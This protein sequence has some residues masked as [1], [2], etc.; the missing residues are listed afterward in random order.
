MV[1]ILATRTAIL[2]LSLLQAGL[3]TS[4]LAAPTAT[5]A[6]VHSMIKSNA[7]KP[8]A[9]G[10][11]GASGSSA[12]DHSNPRA[13]AVANVQ[14][15]HEEVQGHNSII[16]SICEKDKFD[17]TYL[18]Q[19]STHQEF[20][21]MIGVIEDRIAKTG[22]QAVSKKASQR[23]SEY[24]QRPDDEGAK[25]GVLWWFDMTVFGG[26]CSKNSE[27]QYKEYGTDMYSDY[28]TAYFHWSGA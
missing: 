11:S 6:P 22:D 24:N 2:S 25:K 26:M 10:T 5:V 13:R 15:R 8:L 21:Q 28:C 12:P 14:N 4:V 17:F 19:H 1:K 20:R 3:I 16:D 9:S 27:Y 7:M 23:I 18:L